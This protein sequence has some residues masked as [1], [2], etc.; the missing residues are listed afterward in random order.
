M[1]RMAAVEGQPLA[2]LIYAE[3]SPERMAIDG[4]NAVVSEGVCRVVVP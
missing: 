4:T 2:G 3:K 1:L